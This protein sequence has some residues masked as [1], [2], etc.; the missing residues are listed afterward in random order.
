[1][2]SNRTPLLKIALLG[3]AV[4]ILGMGGS[5]LHDL[6]AVQ[7]TAAGGRGPLPIYRPPMQVATVGFVIFTG[8]MLIWAGMMIVDWARGR[9]G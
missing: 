8:A 1:M 4:Y 9:K 5:G 2:S 6:L 3:C 7:S